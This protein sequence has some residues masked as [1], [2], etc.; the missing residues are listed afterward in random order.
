MIIGYGLAGQ[1]DV[2]PITEWRIYRA[3][4]AF[5][6]LQNRQTIGTSRSWR[7][8]PQRLMVF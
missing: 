3:F 5:W 6:H 2:I 1:P 7:A 8:V 4:R